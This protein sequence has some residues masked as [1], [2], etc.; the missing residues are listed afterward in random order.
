MKKLLFIFGVAALIM[1]GCNKAETTGGPGRLSV[2][3]TDAPFDIASVEAAYITIS[4][5]EIRQVNT[6]D[7]YPFL[8]LPLEPVT[9]NVF[10]LRNGI[11]EELVNLEVPV[12]DYDLVRIYVD[13]AKLKLK[14]NDEEFVMKVPSGEQTGIK[15]FVDPVIHIE[16][17]ISAELLLDFDLSQSFV[18]RGHDARN[19]FIFKPCIR[20]ANISTAGRIE[21]FVTDDT[22]APVEN[23][24][25]D[26]QK[27]TDEPLTALT[28]ETGHYAFI[29]V[30]AGTYSMKASMDNYVEAIAESVSV[31]AGNKTTQNFVLKGLPVYVSS[32]IENAAPAVI[33]ITFSLPLVN[34][35]LPEAAA[36]AVTVSTVTRA[37]NSVAIDGTKVKL[38]LASAALKG[39]AV[40]VAYTKPALNPLKT[41]D[42]LE[43][44]SFTAKNVTNNVN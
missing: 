35:N 25:V 23:A 28:D 26:L 16:G 21:G 32:V 12:G 34:T 2:K 33:E 22:E 24:K 14:G 7:S 43:V 37:V 15:L 44:P 42:N 39:E 5:I 1:S 10:E 9:I 18:M 27:G 11:T 41:A 29:G 38:T 3:I 19:G 20:A 40:T 36:F 6:D 13:E 8:E 30:P 4:K 17:G 31:V